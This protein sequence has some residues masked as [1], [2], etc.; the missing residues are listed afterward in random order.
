M[1]FP[2]KNKTILF[3]IIATVVMIVVF[4][5]HK[6][7]NETTNKCPEFIGCTIP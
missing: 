2:V 6:I 7:I 4:N 3:L 1:E 5:K